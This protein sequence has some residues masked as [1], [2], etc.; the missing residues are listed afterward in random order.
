MSIIHPKE[1]NGVEITN[2]DV[3]GTAITYSRTDARPYLGD[4]DALCKKFW[5]KNPKMINRLQEAVKENAEYITAFRDDLES[6]LLDVMNEYLLTPKDQ[7]VYEIENVE[8]SEEGGT[9][10]E[11]I[12]HCGLQHLTFRVDL[13]SNEVEI[14][15]SIDGSVSL[16]NNNDYYRI[17]KMAANAFENC[18]ELSTILLE[19]FNFYHENIKRIRDLINERTEA[20][21]QPIVD[22]Y[23]TLNSYLKKFEKFLNKL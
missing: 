23:G 12:I 17:Y 21:A 8:I 11:V 4:K 19:K 20:L 14:Y 6:T 10:H 16:S 3:R 7:E 22:N 18:E 1:H 2:E 13:H 15:T 5:I 9:T